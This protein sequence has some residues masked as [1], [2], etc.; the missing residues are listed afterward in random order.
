VSEIAAT[1]DGLRDRARKDRR[2]ANLMGVPLAAWQGQL[3][4]YQ[5]SGEIDL[6]AALDNLG[7]FT[8]DAQK[9]RIASLMARVKTHNEAVTAGWEKYKDE[10]EMREYVDRWSAFESEALSLSKRAEEVFA[11]ITDSDIASAEARLN[12]LADEFNKT[13]E[14]RIVLRRQGK[15][16][17]AMEAT[18][19]RIKDKGPAGPD[20]G[21]PS[22][23]VRVP[24]PSQHMD[25]STVTQAPPGPG[26]PSAPSG[27]ALGK[28]KWPLL[29]AAGGLVVV[30]L[31]R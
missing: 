30:A 13:L 24:D 25:P 2:L 23:Q 19:Q 10:P 31:R 15:Q 8:S 27:F 12:L 18:V 22:V 17:K 4:G 7:A 16:I 11:Y 3:A 29:A 6:G 5:R 1:W 9:T 26:V 28:Y 14:N 21:A 20:T